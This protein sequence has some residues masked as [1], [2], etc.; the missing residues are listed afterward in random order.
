MLVI[1]KINTKS[2]EVNCL[3]PWQRCQ[4]KGLLIIEM[5]NE[6]RSASVRTT[7]SLFHHRES[8]FLSIH[9][10][11]GLVEFDLALI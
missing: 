6:L 3:A 11:K 8:R 5:H 1:N 4:K 7:Y 9:G 10:A 2:N